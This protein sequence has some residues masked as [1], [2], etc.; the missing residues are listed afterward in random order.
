MASNSNRR[1]ASSDPSKKRRSIY[2]GAAKRDER[3]DRMRPKV[4]EDSSRARTDPGSVGAKAADAKR[5]ERESRLSS[6]RRSTRLRIAA[7]VAVVVL[8]IGGCIALSRLPL[9]PVR[10]VEV[11]GTSRIPTERILALAQVPADATLINFPADAV[12]ERVAKEPWVASVTVSRVFPDGM[13]IRV[14]ER[15]PVAV[16]DAGKVFWLVDS[17][18]TIIAKPSGNETATLC[19]IRDVPGL[20]PAPGRKTTSEPLLNALKVFEGIQRDLAAQ[21]R[22]ISAPSIDGTTLYTRD[23]VEI[24]FGAA[25]ELAKKDA[26]IRKI[27]ADNRGRVVSIDVRT[28]DRP[29]WRGL[30]P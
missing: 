1:S 5:E 7:V 12:A 3:L 23:K 22:V 6:Q 2:I 13:R 21:V 9:F 14:T 18:G 16:V 25:T 20:D 27:L 24:V 4:R 28:T 17:G 30:T 15:V 19:S 10:R 26:L 11:V 29:T 8:V